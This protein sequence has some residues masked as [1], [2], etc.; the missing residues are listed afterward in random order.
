MPPGDAAAGMTTEHDDLLARAAQQLDRLPPALVSHRLTLGEYQSML[1]AADEVLAE[2]R[3]W[4]TTRAGVL[5]WQD[6]DPWAGTPTA[7]LNR[8]PLQCIR[9]ARRGLRTSTGAL[10]PATDPL[11][12]PFAD[13]TRLM[14]LARDRIRTH[15][16][17]DGHPLTDHGRMAST[18]GGHL[19][20]LARVGEVCAGTAGALRDIAAAAPAEV[21]GDRPQLSEGARVLDQAAAH[22]RAATAG[23]P[24]SLGALVSAP[25][26]T[27]VMLSA[28]ETPR[29]RLKLV[30]EGCD[31]LRLGV[32]R[33]AR[34]PDLGAH[35]SG[36]DLIDTARSLALA[37]LLAGRLIRTVGPAALPDGENTAGLADSF[38]ST[39]QALRATAEAWTRVVDL[40]DPRAASIPPDP[41]PASPPGGYVR[42]RNTPRPPLPRPPAHPAVA[43]AENLAVRVGRLLFTDD[44]HPERPAFA[45]SRS[46]A[47]ILTETGG[48][49][50]LL[51]ALG[52]L[53][54][55]ALSLAA[56]APRVIARLA[57]G[58]V[59]DDQS[60]RPPR[61]PG[62]Y[63]WFPVTPA[64][65]AALAATYAT[66]AEAAGVTAAYFRKIAI[67]Q[68]HAIRSRATLHPTRAAAMPSPE[69]AECRH[70]NRAL[71]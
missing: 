10:A 37:H 16:D 5:G 7:D 41:A 42:R 43:D 23:A 67:P 33:A 39:A 44:W 32:D 6:S 22:L 11:A 29:A 20:V 35:L 8:V 24:A 50:P 59:T 66:A 13:A 45:V 36:S 60:H 4:I 17:A 1:V 30:A 14:R 48:P 58:L 2:A 38:R 28:D 71:R 63:H 53:P 3:R 25:L 46:P 21:L 65:V 52:H 47:Q 27:P 68:P 12:V 19:V 69:A 40:G 62:T 31:R 57:P 34:R 18:P 51:R 55:A 56:Q 70:A 54:S 49:A 15:Y 26:L 9:T 61:F 64:Q